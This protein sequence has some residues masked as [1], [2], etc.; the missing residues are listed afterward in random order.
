VANI[1]DNTESVRAA[2]RAVSRVLDGDMTCE[3]CKRPALVA[4]ARWV[5][6]PNRPVWCCDACATDGEQWL[7]RVN[8]QQRAERAAEI[9]SGVRSVGGAA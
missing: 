9:L 4:G 3:R 5:W 1:D 2:A 8:R 7:E 6:T